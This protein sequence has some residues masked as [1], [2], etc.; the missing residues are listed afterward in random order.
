MFS[1]F[2]SYLYLSD[3]FLL[4]SLRGIKPL[5]LRCAISVKPALPA[6]CLFIASAVLG[7]VS[8]K[9]SSSK[10][11]KFCSFTKFLNCFINLSLCLAPLLFVLAFHSYSLIVELTYQFVEQPH[12]RHLDYF[13]FAPVHYQLV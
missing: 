3:T 2:S 1:F 7:G 8:F 13:S 11:F 4:P 12:E 5:A 9:T 6:L 10:S